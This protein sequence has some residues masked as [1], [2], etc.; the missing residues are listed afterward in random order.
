MA[1]ASGAMLAIGA[2]SAFSQ[3]RNSQNEAEGIRMKTEFEARQLD[4]NRDLAAFQAEDAIRRGDKE[5]VAKQKQTK[6][7]I[8]AQKVALAASG[9]EIDSGS[10][11]DIMEDTA[12]IGA[13]DVMTIKNNAWREAWGYKVQANNLKGQSE[14]SRIAGANASRNTLAAGNMNALTSFGKTAFGMR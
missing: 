7:L 13:S 14:F 12:A 8:G 6:Q 11:L 5:A 1:A 9:V 10:A 4:L 2:V 3:I